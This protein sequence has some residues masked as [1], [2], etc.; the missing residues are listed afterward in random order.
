MTAIHIEGRGGR[1][2]HDVLLA[3]K[4]SIDILRGKREEVKGREDGEYE[5][6]KEGRKGGR[7]E[8]KKGGGRK[9]GREERR[10]EGREEGMHK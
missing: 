10:K 6:R 2:P 3:A 7:K 5:L 8:G 1:R 4:R 9:G